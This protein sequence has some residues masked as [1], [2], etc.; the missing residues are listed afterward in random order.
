MGDLL[1]CAFNGCLK[2]SKGFL[3]VDFKPLH[4]EAKCIAM[5]S[6]MVL[7][8]NGFK[9]FGLGHLWFF[10]EVVIVIVKHKNS[11]LQIALSGI[12]GVACQ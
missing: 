6:A 4:K 2:V 11:S 8:T 9:K 1:L 7:L 5:I 12:G 10:E 3:F